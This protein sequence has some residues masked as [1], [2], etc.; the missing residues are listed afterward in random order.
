M[1]IHLK[2]PC[3]L[4]VLHV[5][6]EVSSS[7]EVMNLNAP[8]RCVVVIYASCGLQGFWD[9]PCHWVSGIFTLSGLKGL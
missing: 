1:N 8:C 5:C 3:D 6:L 4:Q 9:V 2:T 7:L